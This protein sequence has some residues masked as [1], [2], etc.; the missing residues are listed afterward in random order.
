MNTNNRKTADPKVERI[1]RWRESLAT[2]PDERFFEIIRIYLGE[3]HTPFNKDRLIEQLSSIFRKEQTK[4]TITAF[5]S[6]FD[7]KM[8]SAISIVPSATQEKLAEFF[9]GEHSLSDIYSEL[10]NLNERLLIYTYKDSE[11]NSSVIAVN[12]LLEEVL[13]P[14]I[15]VQHLFRR[16]E[17]ISRNLDVHFTLSPL[18]LASFLSY[19]ES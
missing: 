19:I 4:K 16:P 13:S 5:L 2:M 15:G 10:L 3:I 6:E 12:P 1:I 17:C 8:L 14:F 7:I 9:S 11:A 18:F